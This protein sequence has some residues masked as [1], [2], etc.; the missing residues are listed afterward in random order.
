MLNNRS[1]LLFADLLVLSVIYVTCIWLVALPAARASP[2][3]IS[4]AIA[5]DLTLVASLIHYSLAIRPGRW[6]AWTAVPVLVLGITIASALT[7]VGAIPNPVVVVLGAAELSLVALLT[8]R[9]RTIARAYRR[10]RR[11]GA[12]GDDALERALTSALPSR[13]LSRLVAAEISMGVHAICGWWR[14]PRPADGDLLFTAH[15]ESLWI[16]LAAIIGLLTLVEGVAVHLFVADLWSPTAAII[17]S[18]LHGYGLMWLIGDAQALRLHPTRITPAVVELR[19]GLR[20][21]ADIPVGWIDH[22]EPIDEAAADDLSLVVMGG[23]VVRVTS[24]QPVEVR[25]PMGLRRQGSRLAIQIDERD[26]FVEAVRRAC[27]DR[28][29]RSRSPAH[30]SLGPAQK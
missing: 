9:I 18:A 5:L 4:T 27:R 7:D 23:P 10:L 24:N 14:K 20:W 3:L 13:T 8:V 29:T 28:Q 12:P 19:L 30:A 15:R 26:A 17:L 11:S 25:G 2:M 1:V 22:V 16:P 6:P 21:R